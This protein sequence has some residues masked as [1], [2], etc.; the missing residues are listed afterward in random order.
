MKKIINRKKYDTDTASFI[1]E[2]SKHYRS[3]FRFIHEELYQKK[4][5]EFFLYGEGGPLTRYAEQYNDGK[6]Y[7]SD[8]IPIT[9]EDAMDWIEAHGDADLFEKVFGEIEE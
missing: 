4:T 1:E 9:E 2:Y 3:D 7:G 8:I 6:G 5:G